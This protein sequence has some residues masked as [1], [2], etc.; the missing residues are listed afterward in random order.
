[1]SSLDD[2]VNGAQQ[3][4][5]HRTPPEE[6]RRVVRLVCSYA[7]DADDARELFAVLGLNPRDGRRATDA[8][9][10]SIPIGRRCTAPRGDRPDSTHKLH[11]RPD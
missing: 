5:S 3:T 2:V 9:C 11:N 6:N 1:M 7:H 8:T 4:R 10:P